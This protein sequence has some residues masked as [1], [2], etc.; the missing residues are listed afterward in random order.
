M[1]TLSSATCWLWP[2]PGPQISFTQYVYPLESWPGAGVCLRGARGRVSGHL[3]EAGRTAG[4]KNWKHEFLAGR[5][6][7]ARSSRYMKEEELLSCLAGQS[8]RARRAEVA[9]GVHQGLYHLRLV[10]VF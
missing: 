3:A 5:G 6:Q 7:L 8:G 10:S 1:S 2:P 4:G 9:S